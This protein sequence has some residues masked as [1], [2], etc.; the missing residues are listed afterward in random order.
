MRAEAVGRQ[1]AAVFQ[2]LAVETVDAEHAAAGVGGVVLGG[3]QPLAIPVEHRVSVEV[4]VGLRGDGLQQAAVAQV[5]QVAF[6]AWPP[7]DVERQRLAGVLDDVM[8]ALGDAGGE[9]LTAVQAIADRV[10]PAVAVVAG[11]EQQRGCGAAAE[12]PA[13]E[14]ERAE[15]RAAEGQ[16]VAAQHL[17]HR[18][19]R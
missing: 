6:G 12:R 19:W 7:R 9:H 10:V 1:L 4:A 13:T 2:A 18:R 15:Q 16:H 17:S 14:A 3:V 8:A 5:D 11:R